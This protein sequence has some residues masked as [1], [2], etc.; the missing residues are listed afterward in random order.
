MSTENE[1]TKAEETKE[2]PQPTAETTGAPQKPASLEQA[3]KE[4]V[5]TI[6]QKRVEMQGQVR[7]V[8]N[9]MKEKGYFDHV[10][11]EGMK[12]E[13]DAVFLNQINRFLGF[14]EDYV[15]K[16]E[17][18]TGQVMA[19]LNASLVD[20][21]ILTT[22]LMDVHKKAVD[23]GLTVTKEEHEKAE[24]KK[25]VQKINV[26]SKKKKAKAEPTSEEEG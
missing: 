22:S 7:E 3:E 8:Q 24:A 1:N 15:Y 23:D 9:A 17:E 11:P 20:N 18:L 19:I 2:T 5:Q 13:V 21:C 4:V 6:L 14:Q 25:K 10:Y 16:L 26:G 12:V